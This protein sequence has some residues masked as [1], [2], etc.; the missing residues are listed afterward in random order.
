[1]EEK[2][3]KVPFCIFSSLDENMVNFY[4][5]DTVEGDKFEIDLKLPCARANQ[6]TTS[7]VCPLFHFSA[8]YIS[9]FCPLF[10]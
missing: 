3:K 10:Q 9:L 5:A 4:K 1:M 6:I 8:R 2:H 7:S